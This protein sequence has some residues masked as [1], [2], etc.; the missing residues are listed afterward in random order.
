[1]NR[2]RLFT[3]LITAW[4]ITSFSFAQDGVSIGNWRTHLPYEKVIGV[5]PVGS[6]IYAAT[7]YELF[8]Y[9]TQDNSVN[10]LNK[11]NGLSD[12]GI[13]TIGYNKSQRKLFVAYTN[14]NVD[15]IDNDGNIHNMS[16][17]KDNKNIVGNKSINHVFFDGDL[18]YVACGFGIV[19]FD[20]KKEEVKDTYY[21]GNQGDMINVTDI[22]FYNG[23]IYACTDDGVY[24]AAQ[25]APNLANYAVWHFDS[26]LIHP[27][28][29][30]T[31][32][33]VFADKLLLNYSGGYDADTIFVYDGNQWGYFDKTN[34]SEKREMR[35][36]DDRLLLANRYHV[37]VHD[38]NFNQLQ[39]IHSPGGSIEPWAAAIDNSGK[40]WIGDTQRGLV[41]TTDGWNNLDVKPN[42][43]ASKNVFEL[44]ACGDQ[45]WIATG[46]HASNWGKR[47]MREGVARFDGMW[48]IF[49]NSTLE[50]FDDYT[51]FV[52][53]A[54]NPN[55][56]SVTYVGTWGS[57]IL[58]F[59]DNELVEVYN[60]DNSSLS[61][62]VQDQSL[63]NISGLAFDSKGN[64]W[65]VNTGAAN[66]LSVMEP[67]GV[68]HS[69]NLGGSLSGID[70]G[71]LL[72]DHND[73]KWITRRN[74]EVIVFNDNGTLD[75]STDDQTV[76]LNTATGNGK[77]AGAVSCLTV[78]NNG[79]V[80]V[81][82][83]KGPCLFDDTRKIF[84]GSNF[85]ATQVR[86]PRNDGT[87][88]Y[89]YLFAESNVLSMAAMEGANLIWFGLESGVYLMSFDAKP[90]QIHYFNT[91]NSPLLDNA[92]TTMAV[93]K[94]GE[95]FFGTG[96]GVIS[97]RGEY[98]TPDP[99][100]S[101]VVAYPNPVRPGYNGYVG[102]KGL[103]SNSLVRI[104][105]VDGTFVTQ[106]I[107]EGGQAVWD[108]TNINGQKVEPGV[109]FIF[110][111]TK[112]G[113]DK[114]ATKI[115]ILN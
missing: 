56:P 19:V 12:I 53:T 42:G 1:M 55:D 96:N 26:S 112:K 81:G 43:T 30:Y 48:T 66:I 110:V 71:I 69:Y 111:S 94:S 108:C 2:F 74:G 28:L 16:D 39:S 18:A 14:A 17:I 85:D 41:M 83:D 97:Y 46:G 65:A 100:V 99:Y 8:Y 54:T 45:V 11:I 32:M 24:Y 67:N 21:I 109:Y 61:Y 36:Y 58:K 10:I 90:K 15:L 22:A 52:C 64:L 31:E 93:D 89:D 107:S 72:I 38:R 84:N 5:E 57:G 104:T 34:I 47:Y 98:A 62:W 115:L 40:Y 79:A 70:V 25:D 13:S 80:W 103:V 86:V 73:Y 20:L 50:D 3:L 102:I 114:F 27:H 23:R 60:A 59:K 9:D 68:W 78:D 75:N 101:E 29:A 106:L 77:L 113:T 105:T 88:Q 4:F 82:T 76:N 49:N 33:E 92:V 37:S 51:D 91:D 35:A 95:V 44:N 7:Q 87:D 6:K 63:I